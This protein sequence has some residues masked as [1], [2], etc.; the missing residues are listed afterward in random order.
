MENIRQS[1]SGSIHEMNAKNS[2]SR[3]GSASGPRAAEISP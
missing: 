3:F 2:E 1:N